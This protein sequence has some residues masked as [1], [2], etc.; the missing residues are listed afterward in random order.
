MNMKC[1]SLAAWLGAAAIVLLAGRAEA[2]ES[3]DVIIEWN[4]LLQTTI[5]TSGPAA[6]RYYAMLHIA[7]FDAVNAIDKTYTPYR[8]RVSAY[9]GVSEEAAAAQAAHDVLVFLVPNAQA[10][11]DAALQARLARIATWRAAAGALVGSKTA[12]EII[13][14]REH[15]GEVNPSPPVYQLPPLPG[16]WQ[17]T[18][19]A[20]APATFTHLGDVEPFALLTPTQ[21]L[22]DAPPTLTSEDYAVDFNEVKRIGALTS[23]ERTAEQTQTA[24]LFASIGNR[25]IHFAMWNNIARDVARREYWSLID[26]ARLFALLNASIHDGVQTSHTSK[27]VYG[28]WRPVTAIRRADED[29]NPQTAADTTWT[30]LLTTPSY[31]SHSSNQTC[32]ATSA[33]RALARAFA[34][35]TL[36]FTVT[37][38]G[39]APNPDVTRSYGSFSELAAEQ[40]RSRVYGGIHFTFELSASQESC[41]KVA[42]YVVDH[43]MLPRRPSDRD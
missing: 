6:P 26:T 36:P 13:A 4:Q 8:A 12:Q 17:P 22:P 40:A 32:I 38:V 31:P 7:M 29:L 43:Y 2:T 33:A 34:T 21:Y 16:L 10:T 18:P 30:P 11:Y 39:I 37:W 15:D 14:W 41:T 28:L 42:D 19:P 9:P 24:R 27:F 5:P 35:D 25:T 23:T 1:R 20:F 3:A